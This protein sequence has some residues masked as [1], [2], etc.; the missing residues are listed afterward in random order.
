MRGERFNYCIVSRR[1]AASA[2]RVDAAVAAALVRGEAN[3][4]FRRHHFANQ[5]AHLFQG[6]V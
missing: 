6:V 4:G 1:V 2:P 3:S 5:D